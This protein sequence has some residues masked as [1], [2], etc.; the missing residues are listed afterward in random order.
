MLLGELKALLSDLSPELD[1]QQVSIYPSSRG[2]Y[3]L[4]VSRSCKGIGSWGTV[5]PGHIAKWERLT[6]PGGSP[7]FNRIEELK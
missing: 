4:I 6:F 5:L 2:D 1:K 7:S 3:I